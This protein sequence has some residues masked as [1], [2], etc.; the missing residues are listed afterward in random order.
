MS[1]FGNG[2]FASVL[3]RNNK[4]IRDDR[5]MSIVEDAQLIY[6]RKIEDMEMEI[7]RLKRRRENM[8]DLSPG[9]SYSLML[10]D[11]FDAEKFAAE[12]V[13]I[14]VQIS[15]LEIQIEIAN[16]RYLYLFQ[17]KESPLTVSSEN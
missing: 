17:G 15:N 11:K 7:T 2:A 4:Q 8:L 9:N 16:E 3:K 13:N 10:A 12:D 14:G 6:K 5:A 1:E